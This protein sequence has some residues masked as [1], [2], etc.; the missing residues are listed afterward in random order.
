[1]RDPGHQRYELIERI[2]TGGMAE[3]FRARATGEHG[4]EKK[5]AIKRILPSLASDEEFV[6]RFIAEA[7]L[8]V[9]LTHTNIVQIFDFGR[10]AGSLYIAMEFVDGGDLAAL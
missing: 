8:A 4:F 2:A 10:F 7:K 6:A 1:M 5:L 9:A 3:V